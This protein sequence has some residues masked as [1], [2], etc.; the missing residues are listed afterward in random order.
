[1]KNT[2]FVA[3]EDV[4]V[5]NQ[6]NQ[7]TIFKHI[8]RINLVLS[9]EQRK[10]NK[11]ISLKGKFNLV[12]FWSKTKD[13]QEIEIKHK[14]INENGEVF[15]D[16]P[17]HKLQAKGEGTLLKHRLILNQVVIGDSGR[18]FFVLLQKEGDRYKEISKI[19]IDISISTKKPTL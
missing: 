10:E 11:K 9:P 7:W 6:T 14:F 16:I 18:Y 17:D 8:E 13:E 5:D 12:S 15:I 4:S 1:M 3:C 2:L 19:N